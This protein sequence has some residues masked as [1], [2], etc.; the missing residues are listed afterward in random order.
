MLNPSTANE[1]RNDPTIERCERRAKSL[2]F[3]A[4]R[5]VNIFAY[6]ATAPSDLKRV[7]RPVGP[8]NLDAI[9]EALCWGDTIV[10][11]WGTHGDHRNQG[12]KIQKL[13]LQS[14]KPIHH[15][16]LTKHGHPRHP[17]YVSYTQDLIP[18]ND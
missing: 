8:K 14:N 16:G 15:L 7:K 13:L 6:R 4:I 12:A 5:V 18:W 11:A 9:E 17:L 1:L 10:A 3:G 2:D